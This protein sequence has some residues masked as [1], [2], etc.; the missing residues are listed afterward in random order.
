MEFLDKFFDLSPRFYETAHFFSI[1]KKK[2]FLGWRGNP[3]KQDREEKRNNN[4]L[5]LALE[6]GE[7]RMC[8]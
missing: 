5:K 1:K 6:V 8:I 7:L 2:S 3:D 4:F